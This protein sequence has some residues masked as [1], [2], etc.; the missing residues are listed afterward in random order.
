MTAR[1]RR[2]GGDLEIQ[3][4]TKG[5]TLHGILPARENAM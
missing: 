3:S 5:T 2:L 1:L 4:G